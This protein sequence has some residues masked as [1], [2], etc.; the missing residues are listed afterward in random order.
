M[1]FF[2]DKEGNSLTR[3]EYMARWK[4]GME[5]VT[6]LQQAKVSF[7]GMSI[8]MMGILW[9]LL[10]GAY[11]K[12]WWLVIILVGSV[13]VQSMQMLGI[14]QRIQVFNKLLSP[15]ATQSIEMKGDKTDL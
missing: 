7:W 9:G 1:G 6:P 12:H 4:K 3:A 15:V 10:F 13:F 2:K 14:W 5:G 11:F 8:T